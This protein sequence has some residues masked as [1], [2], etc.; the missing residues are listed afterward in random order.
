MPSMGEPVMTHF[1]KTGHNL[2]P[3]HKFRLHEVAVIYESS[4]WR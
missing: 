4:R 1:T 2:N 3:S